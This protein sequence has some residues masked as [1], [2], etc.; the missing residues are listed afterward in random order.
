MIS[1]SFFC[2]NLSRSCTAVLS[3]LRNDRSGFS[4]VSSVI[5][6]FDLVCLFALNR[7]EKN[8][9]LQAL[10]KQI[11]HHPTFL[12]CIHLATMSEQERFR[13]KTKFTSL[14]GKNENVC[15]MSKNEKMHMQ[16]VRKYCFFFV[17]Y[18]NL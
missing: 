18:A 10:T 15:E 1:S 5:A 6:L 14:R 3:L 17:K 12:C 16:N 4:F 13:E 8:V 9:H 2:V 11:Q 7:S